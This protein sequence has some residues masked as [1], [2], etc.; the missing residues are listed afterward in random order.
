MIEIAPCPV[1]Y[2]L[3]DCEHR[4]VEWYGWPGERT[5]GSLC[6]FITR[7]EGSVSRVVAECCRTDVAP[8]NPGLLA[9]FEAGLE[10]VASPEFDR[11]WL[12][13]E[14]RGDVVNFVSD[15]VRSAPGVTLLI[16]EPLV[17]AHPEANDYVSLFA[18]DPVAVRL[19]LLDLLAPL[20]VQFDRL[21]ER[22]AAP[23]SHTEQ[24]GD[25]AK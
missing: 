19:Y 10:V 20:E 1:C 8:A 18:A 9:A 2:A 5:R 16:D 22:R 12:L 13:D 11:E 3:D 21:R 7:M 14:I 6:P 25:A 4:L 23:V 17:S 24:D 15:C